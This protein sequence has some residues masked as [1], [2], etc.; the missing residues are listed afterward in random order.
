MVRFEIY[1]SF[2]TEIGVIGLEG[3]SKGSGKEISKNVRRV[4]AGCM[5][6]SF[7][8]IDMD[9]DSWEWPRTKPEIEKFSYKVLT[10]K[11]GKGRV[12]NNSVYAGV[13]LLD[14]PG[15]YEDVTWEDFEEKKFLS[16]RML[17]HPMMTYG[18][19]KVLVVDNL[20]AMSCYYGDIFMFR[21]R[22]SRSAHK[23]SIDSHKKSIDS[24]NRRNFG[25]IEVFEEKK[26][27][28][29]SCEIENVGHER[30]KKDSVGEE[31]RESDGVNLE[32][33]KKKPIFAK[34]S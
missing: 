9:F 33:K 4:V 27:A 32:L 11:E 29:V 16:V 2:V 28:G 22:T 26:V 14:N 21:F 20:L 1:N 15:S 17:Q 3:Y 7:S 23:K 25:K 30:N 19:G 24:P 8:V 13:N 5:D 31:G 18:A 12:T 6:G 34:V 10:G